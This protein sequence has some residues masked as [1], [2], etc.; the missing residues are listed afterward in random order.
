MDKLLTI[1]EVSALTRLSVASLQAL[2][3]VGSGPAS[4][5]LGRGIV[6][7]E[8]DV[9]AWIEECFAP[10][11]PGAKAVPDDDFPYVTTLLKFR[12]V[13]N[14]E[15]RLLMMLFTYADDPTSPHPRVTSPG[16]SRLANGICRNERDVRKQISSLR[17]RGL[18]SATDPALGGRS[19]ASYILTFPQSN[20]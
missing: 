15:F 16:A 2:R 12:G 11:P 8:A 20:T 13:T 18:I 7:K 10:D 19:T 5:K 17:A 14:A 6:Y 4:A 3:R 1:Q 9:N